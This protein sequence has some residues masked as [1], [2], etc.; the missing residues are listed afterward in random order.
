TTFAGL[1][2]TL[3]I[4]RENGVLKQIRGTPLPAAVYL[5]GL[6][7]SLVLVL[8]LEALVVVGLGRL[9]FGVPFPGSGAGLGAAGGVGAACFAPL[10]VALSGFVPNAEGS[11]AVVNAVYVPMLLLSGAFFPIH[12]LPSFLRGIADALPL[13]HLL[14]S[15]RAAFDGRPAFGDRAGL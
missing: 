7:G 13:T 15:F 1:A 10:G 6:I 9:A 14:T 8:V 12:E 3:T 4:R 2:I 11:S 5:G